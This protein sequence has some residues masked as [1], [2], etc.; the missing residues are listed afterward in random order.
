MSA[1][2]I[3][4]L[5]GKIISMMPVVGIVCKLM[6]KNL[7]RVIESRSSWD[8]VM[9]VSVFEGCEQELLF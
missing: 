3:A 9:N 6:T 1:R 5:S 4:R 2:E 8:A 7:Y